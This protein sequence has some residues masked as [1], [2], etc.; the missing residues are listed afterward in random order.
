MMDWLLILAQTSSPA[1]KGELPQSYF[2]YGMLIFLGVFYFVL[3]RS[4]SREQKK[5]ESLLSGLKKG[6]RVETIGGLFGTIVDV[7]DSEVVLKVDENNN[8]KLRFNR[9]AIKR[10]IQETPEPK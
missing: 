1:P 10:V 7:R 5:V 3:F 4:R 9:I 8:V 2:L 6:D